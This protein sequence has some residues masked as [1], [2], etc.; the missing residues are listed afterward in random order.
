MPY[1]FR[2]AVAD[3]DILVKTNTPIDEH[4]RKNTTSVYTAGEIFP[5]LPEKLST[6][7][8][9]LS[10]QQ[11]RQAIV[12]DMVIDDAGELKDCDIYPAAVHNY[13]KLAY[14]TVGAWLEGTG[15]FWTL[16]R[17]SPCLPIIFAS[18]TG[19]PRS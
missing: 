16:Y 19:W 18:R 11:D 13:A 17:L 9:S 7:L 5:M 4:A 3:V 12:I 2:V 15:P 10:F 14:R 1:G 6:D 8:T